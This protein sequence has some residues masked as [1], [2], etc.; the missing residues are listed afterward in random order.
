MATSAKGLESGESGARTIFIGRNYR[1]ID[2]PGS[3]FGGCLIMQPANELPP[4]H[5]VAAWLA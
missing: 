5:P 3:F 4:R 1:V 2:A